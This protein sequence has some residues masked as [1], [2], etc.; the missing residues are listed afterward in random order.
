VPRIVHVNGRFVREDKAMISVFDRAFLFGD[1]IYEV[2]A[3]IGGRILEWQGHLDRLTRSLAAIGMDLPRSGEELLAI[4]RTLIRRNRLDEGRIYLQ[5]TRG[6]ADRDFAFPPA[7]TPQSLVLFTQAAPVV[8]TKEAE[9]GIGLVS[10]PDIRW[11]RRDIKSTSLLAQVLTKQ[12]AR[13]KGGKEAV[14]H[15]DGVVTEGGASTLFLVTREGRIVTRPDSTKILP[16]V[17]RASL[18][19]M[20]AE[21][22][23]VIEERAFTLDEMRGAAEVFL[24][25]ASAFVLPCVRLDGDPIGEGR[26]G[27]VVQRLRAIYLDEALRT[28]V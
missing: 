18:Q 8:A 12:E 28:A 14:M 13:A 19:R 15:E 10:V 4:H 7:G 27:P 16:G 17:T 1:G 25:A 20:A 6:A 26:P 3:V 5:V 22:Q 2:V 23:M 9:H 21:R 24:T 11:A